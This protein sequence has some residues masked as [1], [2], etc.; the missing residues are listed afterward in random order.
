MIPIL[1]KLKK[2]EHKPGSFLTGWSCENVLSLEACFSTSRRTSYQLGLPVSVQVTHQTSP[3]TDPPRGC[4]PT[5]DLNLPIL[6]QKMKGCVISVGRLCYWLY[7]NKQSKEL[8]IGNSNVK[9]PIE[10]I[11]WELH[12]KEKR[13]HLTA[14]LLHIQI[15]QESPER[16]Q[17]HP[18]RNQQTYLSKSWMKSWKQLLMASN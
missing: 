14:V 9:C 3:G 12:K 4:L 1:F 10:D 2:F 7:W 18:Q 16:H 6:T 15:L 8:E 17:W 11:N 5:L 13:G